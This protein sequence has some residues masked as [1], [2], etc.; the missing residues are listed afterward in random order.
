MFNYYIDYNGKSYTLPEIY[1][2][3]Y[4]VDPA[5]KTLTKTNISLAADVYANEN[6]LILCYELAGI[7]PA[8][9]EIKAEKEELSIKAEK[10]SPNIEGY[11]VLRNEIHYGK[12]YRAFTVG[13]EYDLNSLEANYENGILQIKVP[14]KPETKPKTFKVNTTKQLKE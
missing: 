7:N 1:A 4:G 14:R 5:K 2:L 3:F 9:V 8:T 10:L 6:E 12:C 11:N 13:A